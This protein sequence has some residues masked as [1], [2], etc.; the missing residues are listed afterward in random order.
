MNTWGISSWSI[1]IDANHTLFAGFWFPRGR[2][3]IAPVR[4]LHL[5]CLTINICQYQA[6]FFLRENQCSDVCRMFYSIHGLKSRINQGSGDKRLRD[7]VSHGKLPV[8]M[9]LW[10]AIV[11]DLWYGYKFPH[12]STFDLYT[13]KYHDQMTKFETFYFSSS[14]QAQV[15]LLHCDAYVAFWG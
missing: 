1:D 4:P 15:Q 8:W 10:A 9:D 14:Q 3:Q 7:S 12:F 2:P 6:D 11:V 13:R 5:N